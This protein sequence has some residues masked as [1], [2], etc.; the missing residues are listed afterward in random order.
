VTV[1]QSRGENIPESA[2]NVPGDYRRGFHN[3]G[4]L[5]PRADGFRSLCRCPRLDKPASVAIIAEMPRLR[6]Y[7][8]PVKRSGGLV[9]ESRMRSEDD[10]SEK[11]ALDGGN[12]KEGCVMVTE[13]GLGSTPQRPTP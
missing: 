12:L 1:L 5:Q 6:C 4:M 3:D 8:R 2:G 11:N 9:Q 7:P 10:R 13:R